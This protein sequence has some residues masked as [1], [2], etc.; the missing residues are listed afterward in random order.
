MNRYI[1]LRL[2]LLVT[3]YHIS[4]ILPRM[5]IR[6]FINQSTINISVRIQCKLMIFV[7]N[8]IIYLMIILKIKIIIIVYSIDIHDFTVNA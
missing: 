7:V 1:D 6:N 2:I 5:F 8:K 3:G 4:L